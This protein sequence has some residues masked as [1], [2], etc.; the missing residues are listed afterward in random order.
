MILYDQNRTYVVIKNLEKK[1]LSNKKHDLKGEGNT[2]K[3]VNNIEQ[4]QKIHN[5]D[6]NFQQP[7]IISDKIKTKTE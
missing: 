7:Y 4:C 1:R 6:I 5:I 2:G 3:N